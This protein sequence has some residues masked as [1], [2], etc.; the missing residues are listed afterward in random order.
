MT[1]TVFITGASSG[2]GEKTARVFAGKGWNVVATMRDPAKGA[3]LATNPATKIV[4]LDVTDEASIRWAIAQAM[5]AFGGIDVLVNNAGVGHFGIFEATAREKAVEQFEINVLGL[6]DVTRGIIPHFRARKGGTI[7]NISSLMGLVGL[8]MG[9]LYTAAKYA[10]EGFTE[11]VSYELGALG[12]RVKL[13]EPGAVTG[14]L[15]AERAGTDNHAAHPAPEY[16]AFLAQTGRTYEAVWAA[17]AQSTSAQDVAETIFRAAT[18]GTD[19]MRYIASE[20]AI[21]LAQSR[22]EDGEEVYQGKMR[23]MFALQ[24]AEA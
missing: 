12:I 15:F 10:V 5:E 21:P 16:E 4:Q 18:D 9:S 1:K 23:S 24:P 22:F 7:V 13:I 8:P 19:Q 2:F 6:M 11:S 17:A 14:T 3:G 20:A